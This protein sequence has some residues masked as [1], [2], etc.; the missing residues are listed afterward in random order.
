V[1]IVFAASECVPY[2]KTGGLGDVIGALPKALV[3]AGHKVTVYL[4]Y[5][6]SAHEY[7]VSHSRGEWK[8]AV[9]VPSITVTFDYF[10]RFASVLDGGQADGVQFY[11]IKCDEYFDRDGI[12]GQ[13][14]ADFPD[15]AERFA[16]YCR[17]V[18]EASTL[19][20][21]PDVFHAHDWQA[22]L[23]P[24][25]LG[26]T[27]AADP[28]LGKVPTVFTIHNIGYQGVF[29]KDTMVRLCLPWEIFTMNKLE[30]YDE[31]N[32]LK[33]GIVY[34]DWITTVSRTYAH[35]IQTAEY[36]FGMDTIVRRRAAHLTGILNG[37]D[38]SRWNP[39]RDRHIVAK[40]SANDLFGKAQCRE[41][42]LR[43]FGAQNVSP[44][45]P[46]VA[47]ISRMAA[48][49]GFD[50]I[51]GLGDELAKEDMIMIVLGTGQAE[52]RELFR[53]LAS[54]FPGKFLIHLGYDAA[55]AHKIEAGAD[56]FLM[57]SHYEPCGL[58]QIYSLKY[59]T[60][61]VVR[62]TGGLE[63]TVEQCDITLGTGTGFK[64]RE[65]TPAALQRALHA[66][67]IAYKNRTQWQ[68]IMCNG[69]AK[70][71]SWDKAVPEYVAVYE[72]LTKKLEIS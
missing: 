28:V 42:L 24:I 57:P 3:K 43:L 60:V 15:N 50:L 10:N 68:K 63:D 22:A 13:R 27:Y 17:A 5:Y 40:Y 65:Y 61:P 54:R 71:F 29:H 32:L 35:E 9:R 25:L 6:R 52:Y 64:F 38:Y 21:V 2:V 45:T 56:I 26:S 18:L 12:Y 23:I 16:L 34:G 51:A 72:D 8:P 1:H 41:D 19:L 14:D 39:E 20:G 62:A 58:N 59:G 37:V 55:L 33:G 70:D 36:G 66:A 69:M 48:Q 46:I 11:F 7:L 67:L 53:K 4:P 31:V 44:E 30:Q 49:K 47:I